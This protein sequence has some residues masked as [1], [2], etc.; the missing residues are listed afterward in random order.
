MQPDE[1]RLDGQYPMPE[2][3]QPSGY[4]RIVEELSMSPVDAAY[5][6]EPPEP[7]PQDMDFSQ[8]A[9]PDGLEAK[10]RDDWTASGAR[11]EIEAA[12]REAAQEETYA[13]PMDFLQAWS[14]VSPPPEDEPSPLE[15]LLPP[16]GSIFGPRDG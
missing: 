13:T 7:G 4:E 16:H 11:H 9:V 1:F 10:L 6:P 15:E 5:R 8:Y 14:E 3:M 2:E 12:V